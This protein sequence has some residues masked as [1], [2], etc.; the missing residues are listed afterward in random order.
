MSPALPTGHLRTL[1]YATFA[2]TVGSG[3]WTA[4]SALYLTRGVGLPVVSVG[5]GLSVAGVVGLA[6]SIPLGQLAD[7][8]DPRSVRAVLQGLQ[9]AVAAACL[10]VDAFSVFLCV[11]VLDALLRAE[12][13]SVRAALVAAVGG[14]HG[15][16]RA[17]ATLRAVASAGIGL[18]ACLAA[19]ALVADTRWAYVSLMLGNCASY[20]ISAGLLMRLPAFSPGDTPRSDGPAKAF[21]DRPFLAVSA[22]SAVLSVHHV[23]LVLVVPLWIVSRTHA[24]RWAVAVV[25]V[26]N[27]VLTVVLSV[28]LGRGVDT[29]GPAARALRRSGMVLA[30][31]MVLFAAT[32]NLPAR[33]ALGLLMIAT[34]VYTVGDLLH[35]TAAAGVSYDLAA[36][37][38][39]GQYQGASVLLTGLAEAVA[40]AV[41]VAL[42]VDGGGLPQW[43]GL[44]VLFVCAG[45]VAPT[46]A[47]RALATGGRSR[48]TT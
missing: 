36:P 22:M 20:L 45:L 42:I 38:A 13:L 28:R 11:A 43:T 9:A 21:R 18:G 35:A 24:P 25:L 30:V 19:V 27:T 29:A 31:A 2:N 26:T 5:V 47:R 32:E 23:V 4:G 10:L 41:L 37:G 6:A 34:A 1:S 16:V 33:P 7:R 39:L 14:P 12:N 15:R 3:L 48:I 40:P 44:G 17:F 8:R 46:L